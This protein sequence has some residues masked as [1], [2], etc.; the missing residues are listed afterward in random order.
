MCH[1]VCSLCASGRVKIKTTDEK[2]G[3]LIT[4]ST[5]PILQSAAPKLQS[6]AI[7]T[8]LT[9]HPLNFTA[10]CCISHHQHGCTQLFAALPWLIHARWWTHWYMFTRQ[11]CVYIQKNGHWEYMM[12]QHI[13]ELFTHTKLFSSSKKHHKLITEVVQM[14]LYS[15][16]SQTVR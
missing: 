5:V 4:F 2:Q 10:C 13:V 12:S 16:F 7:P 14:A 3:N 6:I 15:K 1:S 9:D 11:K 8:P